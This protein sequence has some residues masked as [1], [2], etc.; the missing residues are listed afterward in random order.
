[1]K[2]INKARSFFLDLHGYN[3]VDAEKTLEDFIKTCIYKE[4]R[5]ILIVTGKKK[6]M[7]G[8]KSILRELVP[9]GSMKINIFLLF[10]HIVS[11][12]KETEEMEQG[13]FY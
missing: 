2:R 12:S 5:C 8:S 13:M 11:L 6:S 4:K 1:M 10:W 9:N 7:L 3:R